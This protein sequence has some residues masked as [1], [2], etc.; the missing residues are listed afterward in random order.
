MPSLTPKS[1]S[2]LNQK[3]FVDL[4]NSKNFPKCLGI[5]C[6]TIITVIAILTLTFTHQL[7]AATSI[8]TII[9][10]IFKILKVK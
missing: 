4:M 8:A 6:A 3:F 1:K 7:T 2:S 10:P 9:A 5:F